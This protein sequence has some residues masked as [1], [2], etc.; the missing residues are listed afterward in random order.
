MKT[1]IKKIRIVLKFEFN[2]MV[3]IYLN[4]LFILVIFIFT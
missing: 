1:K 2:I 3:D 4:I